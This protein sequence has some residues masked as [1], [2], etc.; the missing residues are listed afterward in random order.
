MREHFLGG[1]QSMNKDCSSVSTFVLPH[2]AKMAGYVPG[3]QPQG[4]GF[5]KLNTNENPYP[6]SP[7]VKSALLEAINDRLRLYPDPLSTAFCKTVA[8]LHNV[9]PDM[10][11]A[12]NGSDDLLTILTRAFVGPG[13]LAAYPSPSY[14]LYSTLIALQNGRSRVVPYQSDWS[15]DPLEC[16]APGL[17]L[18]WLA[19]PD[20]PSGTAMPR[21]QIGRLASTLGCPLVV[22]EAYADF[23]EPGRHSISLIKDHPN[24][25]VTR[26]FS[27]GYG[28]A[29]I[30]L[31]YLITRPELVEHLYKLKDSYNCDMLSQI[32]GN[33]ALSDQ[34]YLDET[35][36]RI[37]ATRSRLTA[38]LRGMGYT[39]PESQSNFVWATGGPP[40]RETFQKLKDRKILVRLMA[41]PGF[42]DGLRMTIGT[43]AEVDR[44]LE[45]LKHLN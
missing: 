20:S 18:F 42:P 23:A 10:V 22:D 28:L 31:G 17:K 24:V 6:P 7:R 39:V 40:A 29:G 25:I 33:A 15:L 45:D 32:A 36:S 43:D 5:I 3:E 35:R 19:N 41:Y 9:S 30:R 12:G 16:A 13:D 8:E 2:I 26:S 27:K 34:D 21:D 44:L 11:M 37:T 38:E 14:L 1:T 4:G